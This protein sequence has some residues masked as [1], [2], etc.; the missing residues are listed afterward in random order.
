[1]PEIAFSDFVPHVVHNPGLRPNSQKVGSIGNITLKKRVSF[2]IVS[3]LW[4][5]VV[6]VLT[7]RKTT[8]CL[9][10][11]AFCRGAL[12]QLRAMKTQNKTAI[13]PPSPFSIQNSQVN[14]LPPRQYAL[15]KHW[16]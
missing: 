15:Q 10:T 12:R 8:A 6:T 13:P 11:T 9:N 14:D 2:V 5:F 7:R 3:S 1:M 4:I 16:Y